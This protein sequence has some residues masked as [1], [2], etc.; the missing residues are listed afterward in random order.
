MVVEQILKD[1]AIA[2]DRVALGKIILRED[3]ITEEQFDY[4]ES[5]LVKVGFE[6]LDDLKQRLIEEVKIYLRQKIEKHEPIKVT[7]EIA[8]LT[9]YDY[10]YVSS[11]FSQSVGVTIEQYII[12]LRIDKAKELLKYD[13]LNFNVIAD[14]LGYSHPSHFSRQFKQQTGTTPTEFRQRYSLKR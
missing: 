2:Y 14:L 7:E 4:L 10:S 6:V 5:A 1:G 12:D 13:D 8:K 9:G 11:L 3:Q